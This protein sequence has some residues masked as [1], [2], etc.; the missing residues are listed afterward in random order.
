[1]LAK[2]AIPA[3][4]VIAIVVLAVIVAPASAAGV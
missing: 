1:M 2:Q 4:L 3:I